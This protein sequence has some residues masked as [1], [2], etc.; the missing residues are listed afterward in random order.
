M[1]FPFEFITVNQLGLFGNLA[2]L[3]FFFLTI[4]YNPKNVLPNIKVLSTK[5]MS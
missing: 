2:E 3:I 4:Y 1:S 5:K